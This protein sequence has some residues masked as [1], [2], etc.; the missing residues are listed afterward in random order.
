MSWRRA[1]P[2]RRSCPSDENPGCY[3]GVANLNTTE[4]ILAAAFGLFL[5]G[6][7]V[8]TAFLSGAPL[9]W[10]VLV[11]GGLTLLGGNLAYS[12]F[13]GRPSW[14]SRVGPLP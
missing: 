9:H 2:W 14:L 1:R 11:G 12:A 7:G 5:A 6:V 3:S 8:Y 4:R 13:S 10:A